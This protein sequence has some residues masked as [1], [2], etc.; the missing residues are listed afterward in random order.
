MEPSK[1]TA[2]TTI[3]INETPKIRVDF[4]LLYNLSKKLAIG[5]TFKVV[6]ND[7]SYEGILEDSG[8]FFSYYLSGV[9]NHISYTFYE[10]TN[11]LIGTFSVWGNLGKITSVQIYINDI[12]LEL[13]FD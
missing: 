1:P 8:T 6:I 9:P 4:D 10:G 13:T 5:D 3:K 2:H 11:S 7:Y 12:E